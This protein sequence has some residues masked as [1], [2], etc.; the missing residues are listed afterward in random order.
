MYYKSE[1]NNFLP[2]SKKE[3]QERGWEQADIILITGDA[4]IDH[5]AFGIAII[6]R[7]LESMGYK[8]AIIP[9][10][11]WQDDLRDFKKLG[12]PKLFF[13]V[14]AGNM[15]SMVNHYTANKRLRSNDAYTPGNKAGFRPDYAVEVY[16]KILKLIYPDIPVVIG[17]I[18]ASLRRLTHYDYW[19]DTIKP[20]VLVTSKADLLV[21]G[22]GEKAIMQIAENLARGKSIS[23][24]T[25]IP[26][27]V[28]ISTSLP[29]DAI[30]LNSFEE[31]IKDKKT[32]AKNFVI[33]EEESNKLEPR[34]L[35]EKTAD[36]WVV[37][38]PPYPPLTEQEM[39]A[40]YDLPY[41]R[42]PHPRYSK[43]EPIPAFEMIKDSITIHRGCFGGCSFCTISAHQGKFISSRSK[44]SIL[45][46]IKKVV[47]M[48]SFKGHITDLGG[49]TAN[50]YKMESIDKEIC[51]KCKKPSCIFPRICKNLNIDLKNLLDLYKYARNIKGVNKITI[52]SGIRYDLIIDNNGKLLNNSAKMYFEELVLHHVSGRLKVAPEHTSKK[53][54][55]LI[56]KPPFELFVHLHNLFYSLN[57]KY[58]LKQELLP[59]FVSSLPGCTIDDMAELATIAK[60]LG[61]STEQVQDF[62][63]TPMTLASVM[64]Y[65]GID[66]YTIK[67]I[68]ISRITSEKKIQQLFF[69]T[70]NAQKQRELKKALLTIDRNDL[71]QKLQ[72]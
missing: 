26:Q 71:L 23:T 60:K 22:M 65:T 53:V 70:H 5:P 43:K 18:E 24:L 17:G 56:R 27:T 19:S 8:V 41:T 6:A 20:S 2:T 39:D 51:K 48:P 9:Q 62:T 57:N 33:I 44:E 1:K 7:L 21:Y 28:Y 61:L 50:M 14:T 25:E 16:T 30:Q 31:C 35:A 47:S 45:K 29:T 68:D 42:L 12:A 11:N 10:P 34:K 58:N 15:D 38:N 55:K 59:Y 3:I 36:K 67:R 63:P 72:L 13:G 37:V 64:Y 4:Y 54:L 66:P 69:F 46:E 49:P 52:G 32:F 40:I